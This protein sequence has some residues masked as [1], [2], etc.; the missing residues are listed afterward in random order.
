MRR[1]IRRLATFLA[2]PVLLVGVAHAQ[3]LDEVIARNL[4]AKG[5]L[6]LLKSTNTVKM[7]G[8]MISQGI[9]VA[10]T[11]LA[12]RPNLVRR[13]ADLPPRV[14]PGAPPDQMMPGQKMITASDGRRVWV[15]MGSSPAQEVPG[16][17][18]AS[19]KNEA[20][21]FDSIFVDYKEKG[22]KVELVGKE[23]RDGKPQYH[24]KVTRRDGPI[25]HYYLDADTGLESK[26]VTD[27]EQEGKKFAVE[28]ELS[29]Y[30]RIAGRTV[31]FLQKQS[32][33]GQTV[34]EMR[35]EA[36]E[37]NLPLDDSLFRFPS[38]K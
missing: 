2:A 9:E 17:Q 3:T 25:Q 14:P 10:M 15:M 1:V 32:S 8:R 20:A 19:I 23:T 30:R 29:Y 36:I 7:T 4:E 22:H 18:A 5:G 16:P 21:E 12:K 26:I 34:A 37:F 13:E 28:M 31:P 27:V 6:D 33:N 11:T 38:S 35:I 24:V